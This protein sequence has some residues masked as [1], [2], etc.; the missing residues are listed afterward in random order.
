MKYLSL[1]SAI[2]GFLTVVVLLSKEN[3]IG[4]VGWFIASSGFFMQCIEEFS[5]D[6]EKQ[7][8]AQS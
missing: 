7:D 2:L 6:K 3:Y 1:S 4:S 8:E 5:K